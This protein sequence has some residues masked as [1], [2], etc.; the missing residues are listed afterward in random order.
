MARNIEIKAHIQSINALLPTVAALAA[1]QPI[2]IEQD[3]TFFRCENGRLKLRELANKS[4][5]LI[6]YRR[7]DQPGPR[8]SFYL[9][10][11]VSNPASLCQTLTAACGQLGRIRKRRLL[12][13]IGRTRVHLDRVE[14][15]G[16]FL[17]LEVVLGDDEPAQAGVDQARQLMSQLGIKPEQ[18]I[19]CAYIDLLGEKHGAS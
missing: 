1:G 8:E 4:G 6:F 14:G 17:E 12:Y 3:D 2:E 7:P 18:L 19:D 13:L 10:T 11:P 9:R 15:L 5:E 16:D